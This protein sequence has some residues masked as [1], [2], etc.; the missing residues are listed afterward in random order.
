VSVMVRPA[1]S[2]DRAAS[3]RTISTYRA[4]VV[5]S[6]F[7]TVLS[8]VGCSKKPGRQVFWWLASGR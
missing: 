7:R 3:I 1:S 6:S 2:A 5:P 8:T 4:G